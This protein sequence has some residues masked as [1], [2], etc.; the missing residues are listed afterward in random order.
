MDEWL[1]ENEWINIYPD[2][3]SIVLNKCFSRGIFL[4]SWTN[5][6]PTYPHF[7]TLFNL[8]LFYSFF[9]FCGK[10]GSGCFL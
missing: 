6:G 3:S 8:V 1:N 4:I 9:S 2:A 10:E 7:P 5:L